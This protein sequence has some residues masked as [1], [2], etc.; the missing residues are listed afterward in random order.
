MSAA[1]IILLVTV[2]SRA[3]D[4][5]SASGDPYARGIVGAASDALGA[6]AQVVSQ[7]VESDPSDAEVLR[8]GEQ[9]GADVVV[10]V[11]WSL[12]DHL[13][14]KIRL[15]RSITGQWVERDLD[16][17]PVDEPA[18]RSR[19]VGLTIALM[20][21]EYADRPEAGAAAPVVAPSVPPAKPEA[22]PARIVASPEPEEP[23]ESPVRHASSLSAAVTAALGVGKN[24]G[25]L[26]GALD[27]RHTL[28]RDLWWRAGVEARFG[29]AGPQV[30]VQEYSGALGIAWSAWT[31]RNGRGSLGLRLDALV[32][33]AHF[34]RTAG[35]GNQDRVKALPGGDVVA[36]AGYYFTRGF[37]GFVGVGAVARFGQ[38]DVVVDGR[39]VATIAPVYPVVEAGLRFGF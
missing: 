10:E 25:A 19:A 8:L 6:H 20:L 27:F 9:V 22:G 18:E 17:R 4:E 21:P 23:P 35:T 24:A 3:A 7:A 36:E 30:S 16:F 32:V 2:S 1:L 12:P 38:T 13:H 15:E 14:T 28:L 37:G 5:G 33:V 31:S 34:V 11:T 29:E 39:S 26:G